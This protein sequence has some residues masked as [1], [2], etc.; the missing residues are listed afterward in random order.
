MYLVPEKKFCDVFPGLHVRAPQKAISLSSTGFP[1]FMASLASTF[2]RLNRVARTAAQ[3][4]RAKLIPYQLVSTF[5]QHAYP[6]FAK[7]TNMGA[8]RSFQSSA[9]MAKNPS[10]SWGDMIPVPR[11]SSSSENPVNKIILSRPQYKRFGQQGPSGSQSGGGR[12]GPPIFYDKRYQVVGG[13][14]TVGAGG[15]YVTHLET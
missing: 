5:H 7:P 4:C 1:H 13:V 9:S 14:I 3:P 15:Y 6:A 11:P 2:T 10:S 8:T 12:R